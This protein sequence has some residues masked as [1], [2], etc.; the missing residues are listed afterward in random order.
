MLKDKPRK[1]IC[2]MKNKF[3]LCGK[4]KENL[5]V[6]ALDNSDYNLCFRHL[7]CW[8]R[9][10]N[11]DHHY[12]DNCNRTSSWILLCSFLDIELL[13]ACQVLQLNPLTAWL[14][15]VHTEYQQRFFGICLQHS[16]M[17]WLHLYWIANPT[18]FNLFYSWEDV[19][20]IAALSYYLWHS[21][22]TIPHRS[23]VLNKELFPTIHFILTSILWGG[24]L[25]KDNYGLKI[26]QWV[27]W[28]NGDLKLAAEYQ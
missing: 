23:S 11:A 27:P 3:W 1:Q 12:K 26:T 9:I 15:K 21:Y 19:H 18:A 24:F 17:A 28:L 8:S 5:L 14:R 20:R 6:V 10:D 16:P 2:D 13:S 4:R 22:T 25:W 7:I